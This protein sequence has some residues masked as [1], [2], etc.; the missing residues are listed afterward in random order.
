MEADD[1][2]PVAEEGVGGGG[3]GGDG[4]GQAGEG[5]GVEEGLG[6]GYGGEEEEGALLIDWFGGQ[7]GGSRMTGDRGKRQREGLGVEFR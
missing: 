6:E 2:E 4:W 7:R 5:G 1:G 3:E